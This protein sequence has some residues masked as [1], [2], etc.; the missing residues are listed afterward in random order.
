MLKSI[1]LA[2]VLIPGQTI[3]IPVRSMEKYN[4]WTN[5]PTWAVH[6]WITNEEWSYKETRRMKFSGPHLKSWWTE[7]CRDYP[8]WAED[9]EPLSEV[10]WEEVS[11]ALKE[12]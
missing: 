2:G 8:L 5:R 1:L 11:E 4:G 12:D 7:V 6:L 9:C 3:F 10:N